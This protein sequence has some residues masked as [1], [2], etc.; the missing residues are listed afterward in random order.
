MG[1]LEK[2]SKQTQKAPKA[3]KAPKR[4][5]K[6]REKEPQKSTPDFKLMIPIEEELPPETIEEILTWG[7]NCAFSLGVASVIRQHHNYDKRVLKHFRIT[8]WFPLSRM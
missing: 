6:R 5:R 7:P 4:K 8:H 3:P 2:V 1:F